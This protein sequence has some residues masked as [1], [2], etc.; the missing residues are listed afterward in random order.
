V[1]GDKA[2]G[3][4]SDGANLYISFGYTFD[5]EPDR[6]NTVNPITTFI[7]PQVGPFYKWGGLGYDGRIYGTEYVSNSG[8]T[9]S[10]YSRVWN[11]NGSAFWDGFAYDSFVYPRLN[12]VD[13][14]GP[15][16]IAV[17]ESSNLLPA[18]SNAILFLHKQSANP[19]FTQFNTGG[20]VTGS[21]ILA[22]TALKGLTANTMTV[23]SE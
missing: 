23:P 1:L 4:T 19:F 12:D 5:A 17:V 8:G 15:N 20:P 18:T 21:G 13:F 9:I 22:N 10:N 14:A 7:G 3:I 6:V 2:R 11:N 16:H